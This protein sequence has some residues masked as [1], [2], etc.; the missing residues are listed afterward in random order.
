MFVDCSTGH[1]WLVQG[2]PADF[3][4]RY[5]ESVRRSGEPLLIAADGR[6]VVETGNDDPLPELNIVIER[7]RGTEPAGTCPARFAAA[8]LV[9][10]VWTLAR[11]GD[12]PVPP[13]TSPTRAMALS[14]R[15][16]SGTFA[17][18]AGCNRFTGPYVL[19]GERLSM[20]GVGS[21]RSC[22]TVTDVDLAFRSAIDR[23]RSF[24]VLGRSLDLYDADQQFVARFTAQ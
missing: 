6:L 8:P 21:L 12:R 3:D 23:V 1:E 7:L 11:L 18:S 13:V 16:E 9:N 5:L 2:K 19:E 14:L 22:P 17:V 20:R 10:T 4:A 24:R 15:E